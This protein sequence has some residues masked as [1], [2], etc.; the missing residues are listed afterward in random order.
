MVRRIV[1]IDNDQDQSFAL[2]DRELKTALLD[3]ARPGF[4]R[5]RIWLTNSSPAKIHDLSW[6]D[7]AP[8]LLEPLESGAVFH[9]YQ[10]PPDSIWRDD[11]NATKIANYFKTVGAEHAMQGD[12]NLHPYL[13]KTQTLDLCVILKGEI[14]LILDKHK[15][16]LYEGDTVVQRATRHTWSNHT[17]AP[18]TVAISSHCARKET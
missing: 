15:V 13:Q 3:P 1:T 8:E 7:E 17:S 5:Q 9:I 10:F 16:V 12:Q 11:I 14:T 4:S 18:C 6:V 2:E